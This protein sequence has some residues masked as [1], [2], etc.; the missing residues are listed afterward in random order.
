MSPARDG[1]QRDATASSATR[2]AA[3]GHPRAIGRP[4]PA[5]LEGSLDLGEALMH[6][7]PG[8][9]GPGPPSRW[10]C[11]DTG[12]L[13]APSPSRQ[14]A[15]AAKKAGMT[16]A[17]GVP[18]I[19]DVPGSVRSSASE[20]RA[21]WPRSGRPSTGSGGRKGLRH[22]GRFDQGVDLVAPT[23]CRVNHGPGR[24]RE[25][26]L[27]GRRRLPRPG[28]KHPADQG[29]RVSEDRLEGRRTASAG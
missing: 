27:A 16:C 10:R 6:D 13:R 9:A 4:R 20:D 22:T 11:R 29:A 3:R 26:P 7:G 18:G 5:G 28:P 17:G 15:T 24:G 14:S 23:P 12:S 19:L 25:D 21:A 2:T 1:Q 8:P